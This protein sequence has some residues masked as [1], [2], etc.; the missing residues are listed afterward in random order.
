LKLCL[1]LCTSLMGLFVAP[2]LTQAQVWPPNVIVILAD[3]FGYGETS[4]Q[5]NPQI[6]T[7]NIDSIASNGVRFTAGY[8]AAVTCSPSRAGLL[9]GR[10]PTRFGHEF[11]PSS[12]RHGLPLSE[13]T[14]A[15]RLRSLGYATA[16]IGKWH[17]GA[18]LS[19]RPSRRG[20]DEF[21]GTPSNTSFFF[22]KKFVD[23]RISDAV[24][25]VTDPT[26][27]TTDAYASRAVHVI[28][29]NRHRPF[30]LYLPFN[31]THA[32]LEAPEKYLA[33]V[34]SSITDPTRRI[35]AAILIG[36][37]DAIGCVLAEVRAIG[38]ESNTL[39][40]FLADNGGRPKIS[41][42]YPL[43]GRK[44]NTLEGGIRVPFMVQWKGRIPAGQ[45]YTHPIVQLDILPT[46]LAAAGRSV[47]PSWRLDGVNLLPYLI[48]GQAGRPHDTLYWRY[49]TQWAIRCGDWK[50]VVSQP[51]GPTPRLFNLGADIIR[52]I[53]QII[54][55]SISAVGVVIALIL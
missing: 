1:A 39:I 31:A 54:F 25:G 37:D 51:D 47:D 19:H 33:R 50:L 11:N 21:Y 42:N 2:A 12:P 8:V 48:Q 6:P 52:D 41:T 13:T 24:Q 44:R 4:A 43:R 29:K 38:Q 36:M 23:S 10:Y 46:S 20:F 30:F 15:E 28:R 16:V 26:F 17:F 32:P 5:G 3:D 35:F 40:W 34:S 9:T 7:P 27:Y 53:V 14:M 22:P 55:Q 49:G 18:R 45:T